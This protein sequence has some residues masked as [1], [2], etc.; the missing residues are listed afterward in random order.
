MIDIVD[1]ETGEKVSEVS[2]PSDLFVK[3]YG[4]KLSVSGVVVPYKTYLQ[5]GSNLKAI[6]FSNCDAIGFT[7]GGADWT[8]STI[9]NV[10]MPGAVLGKIFDGATVSV[11]APGSTIVSDSAVGA[12]FRECDFTGCT[13]V[14][15]FSLAHFEGCNL[16]SA[17]LSGVISLAGTSFDRN[18]NLSR[19]YLGG[20][21]LDEALLNF[22][23]H[24][25]TGTF[26]HQKAKAEGK[27]DYQGYSLF[28]RESEELCHELW[29]PTEGL[30]PLPFVEWAFAHIDKQLRGVGG[31]ISDTFL[32]SIKEVLK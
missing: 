31:V 12:V 21:L 20:V 9:Q 11:G 16:T 24:T 30:Y 29:T 15:T 10:L 13:L 5:S 7:A 4:E 27:V 6:S 17:N 19:A 14:G 26:L 28:I 18:C 25:L 2:S 22:N 23:S 3:A 1:R 8:A 32:N